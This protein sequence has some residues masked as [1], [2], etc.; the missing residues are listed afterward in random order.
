MDKDTIMRQW[1]H[2]G[3]QGS[4]VQERSYRKGNRYFIMSN[5]GHGWRSEPIEVSR[6]D[7]ECCLCDAPE[8]VRRAILGDTPDGLSSEEYRNDIADQEG[9]DQ[10]DGGRGAGSLGQP[11]D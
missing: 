5:W 8:D 2:P 4:T 10:F 1:S 7:M 3:Y 6:Y 9:R 11:V